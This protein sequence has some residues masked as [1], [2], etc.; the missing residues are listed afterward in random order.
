M[1]ILTKLLFSY[2]GKIGRADFIYGMI[3]GYLLAFVSLDALTQPRNWN[4]IG[5][6]IDI[7]F[8]AQYVVSILGITI[9]F[10]ILT[11]IMT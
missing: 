4:L 10:W 5:S 8:V 9:A 11:A 7:G 1:N 6:G 3:Y 2:R